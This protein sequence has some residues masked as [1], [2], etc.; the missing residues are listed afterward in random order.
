M[1]SIG[2]KEV[3]EKAGVAPSTVSRALTDHPRISEDT[4]AKIRKISKELGYIPSK[5]VRNFYL[6]KSFCIAIVWS[7][8]DEYALLS[9]EYISEI[10]FGVLRSANTRNYK[11]ILLTEKEFSAE[12]L[13]TMVRSHEVDGL[14]FPAPKMG[15]RRFSYL[16]QKGIP[17]VLIHYFIKNKPYPYITC[18]A[19]PGMNAAFAYLAEKNITTV[20]FLTGSEKLLDSKLRKQIF[21]KLAKQYHMTVFRIW[22]GSFNKKSGMEAAIAFLKGKLPEVIFCANDAMALGLME[23]FK[24]H[25]VTVP[26]D[27]LLVG[28]DD[29]EL[30]ALTYP[31]LTTIKNPIFKIGSIAG[32]KLISLIEGETIE[33]EILT[34]HLVLRDSA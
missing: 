23:G 22:Q 21:I 5:T 8:Q 17:F 34:S 33:S 26:N 9:H 7:Y 27:V 24:A 12:E 18:D 4:K 29:S 11:V 10:L 14:L 19:E 31:A 15:D 16:Y 25:N 1:S 30:A 3:A 28:F 20:A 32:E 6:N 13:E 2:I